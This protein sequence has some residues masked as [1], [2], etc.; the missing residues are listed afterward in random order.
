MRA[1][2]K[3]SGIPA[4]LVGAIVGTTI[5]I[6]AVSYAQQTPRPTAPAETAAA[7]IEPLHFRGFLPRLVASVPGCDLPARPIQTEGRR[8]EGT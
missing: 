7:R 8:N 3:R 2:L 6:G 4:L 1:S 5:S